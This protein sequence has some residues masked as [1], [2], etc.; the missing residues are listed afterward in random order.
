M[1]RRGRAISVL[2]LAGAG[3]AAYGL[4]Q[5]YAPAGSSFCNIN[6]VVSCDLVNQSVYSEIFGMPVAMVGSLGFLALSGLALAAVRNEKAR[7]YLLAAA[8]FGLAFQLYLSWVEFGLLRAVCPICVV[9]QILIT[10]IVA[11]AIPWR[12]VSLIWSSR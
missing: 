12:Q 2:G 4:W 10:G 9:S 3:D 5:H 11:L 7:P 8:L 6:S 1:V